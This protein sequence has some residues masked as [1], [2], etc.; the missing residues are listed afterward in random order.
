MSLTQH[1]TWY[2][3]LKHHSHLE[4][5]HMFDHTHYHR[6]H[7]VFTTTNRVFLW[8]SL[9]LHSV[10]IT[11]INYH[12]CGNKVNKLAPKYAPQSLFKLIWYTIRYHILH[13]V[14][15]TML[16]ELTPHTLP[17]DTV[18]TTI[19]PTTVLLYYC[20]NYYIICLRWKAFEVYIL[21]ILWH[22]HISSRLI[23]PLIKV[24]TGTDS[25]FPLI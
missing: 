18:F 3:W 12:I 19:T 14:F 13:S 17:L 21:Q 22:S 8:G 10:K 1:Y 20:L 5:F 2:T 4:V 15:T 9:S 11:I 16:S 6:L 7:S 24:G 23:S 25:E